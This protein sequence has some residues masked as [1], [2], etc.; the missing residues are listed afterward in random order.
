[1]ST[2][3]AMGCRN[4]L[5]QLTDSDRLVQTPSVAIDKLVWII[6]F[7]PLL[8]YL[9]VGEHLLFVFIF[10]LDIILQKNLFY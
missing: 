4:T 7:N 10:N 3:P 9:F 1:M 5:T 8:L 6:F 2:A